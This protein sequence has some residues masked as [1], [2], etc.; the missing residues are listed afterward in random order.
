MV[1]IRYDP[2]KLRV[3][4]QTY[5]E[6]QRRLIGVEEI[7]MRSAWEALEDLTGLV[8]LVQANAIRVANGSVLTVF[9]PG[10]GLQH[11]IRLTLIDSESRNIHLSASSFP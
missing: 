3:A 10:V 4:I 8:E 6:Q 2:Q 7:V 5:L 9:G 1:Q 11:G